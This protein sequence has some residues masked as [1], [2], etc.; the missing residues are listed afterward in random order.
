MTAMRIRLL[1]AA[2][3]L[4]LAGFSFAAELPAAHTRDGRAADW[5]AGNKIAVTTRVEVAAEKQPMAW[6]PGE[7]L[8]IE[9]Q[10][11]IDTATTFSRIPARFKGKVT[12]G[13][14]NNGEMSAGVT[15]RFVTDSP[16]ISARWTAP[17]PAMNHM[18]ASGSNG[19]DLYVK[20]S[21]AWEY[22]GTGIPQTTATSTARLFPGKFSSGSTTGTVAAREYL[23]FLPT[24]SATTALEI[25]IS[26]TTSIAP[27]E[28]PEAGKKPVVFYGT[29]I[30][31]GACAPRAGLGHV[32]RLRRALDYPV[33]NLGFSGS[34]KCEPTMAELLAEIPAALYVIETVPNMSSDLIRERTLP[35]LKELRKKQPDTPILMVASPNVWLNAGQNELWKTQF[36]AAKEAGID[37]I[38][39]LAGDGQYGDTDNP[40]VDGVHP[41]DLGFYFMAKYYEP[42]LRKMLNLPSARSRL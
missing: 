7:Q 3:A 34:G 38:F 4:A 36:E 11:F 22:V 32:E 10:G 16:V 1:A 13:V 31:H 29:S 41:T 2:V 37:N 39:F 14:W 42:V 12:G 19:L 40:T 18:A 27:A 21:G 8:L 17:R 15:L 25:G 28:K 6:I 35:F 20:D 26:P 23:L 5:L 9:G 24:Y 30:T 33:I